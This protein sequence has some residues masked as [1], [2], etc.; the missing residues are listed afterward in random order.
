[1]NMKEL[2]IIARNTQVE[3]NALKIEQEGKLL[4][5]KDRLKIVEESCLNTAGISSSRK[6]PKVTETIY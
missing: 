6:Q 1:M 4:V 5:E 2:D 3:V